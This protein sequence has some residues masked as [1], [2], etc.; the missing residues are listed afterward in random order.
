M[1]PTGNNVFYDSTYLPDKI[2]INTYEI[3]NIKVALLKRFF[4][5]NFKRGIEGKKTRR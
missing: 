3:G 4:F 1:S 2:Y 5:E